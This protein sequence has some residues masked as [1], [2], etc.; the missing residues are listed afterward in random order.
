[1]LSISEDSHCRPKAS[2]FSESRLHTSTERSHSKSPSFAQLDP[3]VG[4]KDRAHSGLSVEKQK[5][6]PPSQM[7]IW[8]LSCT[9]SDSD[10]LLSPL[11]RNSGHLL[12]RNPWPRHLGNACTSQIL[13]EN[14][15]ILFPDLGSIKTTEIE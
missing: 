13:S 6:Q 8:K 9:T 4:C 15:H 5:M 11:P 1:M 2:A 14:A 7:K 3:E 10:L 12:F